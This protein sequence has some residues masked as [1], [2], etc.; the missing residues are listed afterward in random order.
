MPDIM[1]PFLPAFTVAGIFKK[2]IRLLEIFLKNFF[3]LPQKKLILSH[4]ARNHSL[5][6]L[7][8]SP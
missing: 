5:A 3:S 6:G 2:N 1:V 8:V 7:H 4:S